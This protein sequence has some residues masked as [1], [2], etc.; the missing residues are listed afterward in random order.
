MR[1]GSESSAFW[2]IFLFT[3]RRAIPRLQYCPFGGALSVVGGVVDVAPAPCPE[4][5]V[6]PGLPVPLEPAL[7]LWPLPVVAGGLC[8]AP[9]VVAPPDVEPVAELPLESLPLPPVELHAARDR[10]IMLLMRRLCTVFMIVS[11]YVGVGTT[12]MSWQAG[13]ENRMAT[14]V[15]VGYAIRSSCQLAILG[16]TGFGPVSGSK[17]LHAI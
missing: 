17:L 14:S 15:F 8:V 9:L 2:A 16:N 12:I 3:L 5:P 10:V 6:V 13:S 1:N 11:F 4:A 7:P